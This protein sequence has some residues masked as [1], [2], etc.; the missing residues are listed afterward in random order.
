LP[1]TLLISDLHLEPGRPDITAALVKFLHSKAKQADALYILGDLF[2]VWIG[3]DFSNPLAD[4][5]AVELT[6]LSSHGVQ[7]YLMHGNRDFL[8]GQDYARS[9][10]AELIDEPYVIDVAGQKVA[11]LHG[12]VLCTRDTDYMAFRAM[13]RQPQ[14]QQQFLSQ[15]P[16]QRQQ[17]AQQ[18]RQQSHQATASKA[19]QIMDVTETEVRQL[20]TKL[21]VPV[22]IHGHTHRPAV[23]QLSVDSTANDT[24]QAKRIVLGDWDQQLWYVEISSAGISLENAPFD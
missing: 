19:A 14:W 7:I 9:C 13:V 17:I 12:D 18:A 23:H 22:I 15:T 3:D 10:S 1:T 6:E 16:Q 21:D 5:I 8:I 20:F 24:I 11:L 2:E 4:Q